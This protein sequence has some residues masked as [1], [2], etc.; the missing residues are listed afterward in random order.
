M[1]VDRHIAARVLEFHRN[2]DF[3]RRGGIVTDL[4]GTALHEDARQ[5]ILALSVEA[6]LS[7]LADLGLS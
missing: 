3:A 4:D 1:K 6:G 7:A 5:L 2:S